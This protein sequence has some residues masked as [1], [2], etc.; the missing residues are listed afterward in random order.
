MTKIAHLGCGYWGRNLVRNFAELGVLAA[1]V[2][3]NPAT[4]A[5]I[6]DAHGAPS[7]RLEE[8]LYDETIDAISIATPAE[9][10]A[11]LAIK[12]FEC[13]KHV[14]V[15][16]PLA[17]TE[18]ECSAMIAAA[19][20]AGRQLM[21]GHLL[22]YHPV[23]RR[24]RQC[25]EEGYIGELQYIYSNRMSLGKFRTEEDVLWSFAPHDVSMVL[26]LTGTIP[27][28]VTSQGAAFATPG[29][30]DWATTQ[31]VFPNGVRGHIQVSWLHPFKEQRLVAIGTNGML[32]FEDSEPEW[33]KKLTFYAHRI[34]CTGP[35]P[36]PNKS[37]AEYLPV[38]KAE[39]LR[40]ECA[41]FV[42]CVRD[43]KTP[44][45]D[46]QEGRDVLDVLVRAGESLKSYLAE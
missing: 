18:A 8:I 27:S 17:L 30:A 7:R 44:L 1:V 20:E 15:E 29:V 3:A 28:R 39:P 14:Y 22:Q 40:A 38:E 46:G 16:K 33:E 36:V 41:H 26:G 45:T 25:V 11:G 6:G 19:H 42:E 9:T 31:M 10:H 37:E 21:V 35:I 5:Q 4:A 43:N 13:G 24:M 2:D 32:V 23:Y 34:D 12:A